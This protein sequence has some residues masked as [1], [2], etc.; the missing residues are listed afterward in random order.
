MKQAVKILNELKAADLKLRDGFHY[1][2]ELID[3]LS[4]VI[5][6]NNLLISKVKKLTSEKPVKISI[7]M[8]KYNT[9]LPVLELN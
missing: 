3:N 2:N 8:K 4:K 1:P 9:Y 7:N 6:T 5:I